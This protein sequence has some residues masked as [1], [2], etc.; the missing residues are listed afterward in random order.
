MQVRN[1]RI[2]VGPGEQTLQSEL[3]SWLRN[4]RN[5]LGEIVIVSGTAGSALTTFIGARKLVNNSVVVAGL[6]TVFF[7]G[8]L[9]V[10]AHLATD[11]TKP[12]HRPRTLVLGITWIL[13]A[14]FSIYSSA[15]GAFE[16]VKDS[17]KKDHSR[18]AM[19]VQW[20]AAEREISDFKTK[21]MSF[22][23]QAK[24]DLEPKLN[25]E[26]ERKR[27][28]DKKN[29]YY[30]TARLQVLT[31]KSNALR[32]A[33]TKI[34]AIQ[35]S[36]TPPANTEGVIRGLDGAFEAAKA[37]Y[38]S[39]PEAAREQFSEPRRS[40]IASSPEDLQKVFWAEVQAGSI[41]AL[42]ILAIAALMDF[43]PALLRYASKSKKTVAE[44]IS[45]A[46]RT[47]KDIWNSLVIPLSPK[48]TAIRVVAAGHADL[49]ITLN[50]ADD[51]H[52]MTLRDIS[53]DLHVVLNEVAR[54]VGHAVR[55]RSAMTTSQMEIVPDLPLLNQLDND[56][57]LHL[58]FED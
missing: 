12:N 53:R 11:R 22:V 26:K 14:F 50:F 15:I 28:A 2:A 19:V 58:Q 23:A 40:T 3:L 51:Y 27:F 13:L 18:G 10:V 4:W 31:A 45:Q 52:H 37:A 46:R 56:L 30:P 54:K 1:E 55:L 24:Q 5:H 41:P 36:G 49:D 32:D 8:G 6:L 44:K 20:Q 9:F 35:L 43:L 38:A 25:L 16:L 34:Q 57:T 39:L 47:G 17:L 21:A 33:E 42:V 29:L 7:Q 48:T